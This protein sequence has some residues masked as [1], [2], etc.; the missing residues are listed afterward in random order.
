[1]MDALL[2]EPKTWLA[3]SFVLF[4]LLF[5]R[6]A[7]PALMRLLDQRAASIKAQLDEAVR[8]RE[9]AQALL[10]EYQQKQKELQAQAEE[11]LNDAKKQAQLMREQA[12]V[13]LQRAIARRAKLAEEK[14]ARAEE[15][16]MAEIKAMAANQA[17]A[18]AKTLIASSMDDTQDE[19]FSLSQL[20]NTKQ[21][22]H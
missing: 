21:L 19:K 18:A 14:I 6:Y 13:E 22:L 20:Q 8:L 3:I 1:M 11:Q 2:Q 9:S 16:A 12:E 10:G 4:L 17:I 7:V 15:E 5:I